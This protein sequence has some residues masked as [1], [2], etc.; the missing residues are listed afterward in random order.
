MRRRKLTKHQPKEMNVMN[1]QDNR[2][3]DNQP[4][5]IEDLG[6]QNAE[7]LKGGPR[8]IVKRDVILKTSATENQ[9]EDDVTMNEATLNHNES[10][11]SDDDEDE[12][13][14]A[15]LADLPVTEERE[16]Q[17]KGG[18]PAIQRVR[19]AAHRLES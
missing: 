19:D 18:L 6:V 3:T 9:S 16:E 4:I 2:E 12:T 15:G 14:A 5:P 7:E 10:V 1:Q 8:P 11:V 13:H 17:V